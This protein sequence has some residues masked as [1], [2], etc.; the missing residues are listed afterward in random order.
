VLGGGGVGRRLVGGGGV[1]L[2]MGARRFLCAPFL[3]QGV[4]TIEVGAERGGE[5]CEQLLAL[6]GRQWQLRVQLGGERAQ[7]PSAGGG[8]HCICGA[9][10]RVCVCVVDVSGRVC[11]VLVVWSSSK[12]DRPRG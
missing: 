1:A 11:G 10:A 7:Q 4:F 12:P 9:P 6:A 2:A 3:W 8:L 5:Q